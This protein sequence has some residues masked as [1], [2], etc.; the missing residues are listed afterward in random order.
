MFRRKNEISQ[1]Q[2][3]LN[4]ADMRFL[5]FSEML[6]IKIFFINKNKI[7]M[8]FVCSECDGNFQNDVTT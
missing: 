8:K 7:I 5:E 4:L 3:T 6:S 2:K 1:I